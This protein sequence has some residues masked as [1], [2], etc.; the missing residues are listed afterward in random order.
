MFR[1]MGNPFVSLISNE[2][3][4]ESYYNFDDV[5]NTKF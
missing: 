2:A 1:I 5:K 4:H 3:V